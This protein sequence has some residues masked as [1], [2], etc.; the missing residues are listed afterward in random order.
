[1]YCLC[2]VKTVIP[3]IERQQ[4]RTATNFTCKC[5]ENFAEFSIHRRVGADRNHN[6]QCLLRGITHGEIVQFFQKYVFKSVISS[7]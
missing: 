6:V 5:Y 3:E 2:L 4:N 1:M 7:S